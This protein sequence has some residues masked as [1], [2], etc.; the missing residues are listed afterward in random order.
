MLWFENDKMNIQLYMKKKPLIYDLMLIGTCFLVTLAQANEGL[1]QAPQS[2][3]P[4]NV[5]DCGI[6]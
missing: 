2:G 3:G 1:Y 4:P 6:F 5:G